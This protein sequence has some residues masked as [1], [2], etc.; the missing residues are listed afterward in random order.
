VLLVPRYLRPDALADQ[1]RHL[2]RFGVATQ[3][4]FG[5]QD[6]TIHG[7]LEPSLGGRDQVEPLD[8]RRPTSEKI[9]RQ[10]DGTGNVVSGN[11]ELDGDVVAG[12]EHASSFRR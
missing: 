9:V 4:G 8:D 1:T 10:T 3:L 11:A 6:L 12:V 2:P 5:E 7:D